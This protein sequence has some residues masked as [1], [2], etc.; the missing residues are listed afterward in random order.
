MK[1]L[2]L[3]LFGLS[4]LLLAGCEGYGD[5]DNVVLTDLPPQQYEPI[6]MDRDEF[7]NAVQMMPSQAI[8]KAGKIYIKDGYLF[9]NDVHRGFHIYDYSNPIN[10]IALGFINVPGSTDLAVR[11]NVVYINQAT[12]LV[13]MVFDSAANTMTL[14][15]RNENVFPAMPSP[16]GSVEDVANDEVIIGWELI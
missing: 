6:T 15:K 7:E 1:Q 12:D 14:V 13:T 11:D 3:L 9:I 2:Q 4:I 16:D 10:P 5:A 8:V